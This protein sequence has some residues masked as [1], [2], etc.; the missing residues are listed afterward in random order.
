MLDVW[1]K[2]P[3]R[4]IC[5]GPGGQTARFVAGLAVSATVRRARAQSGTTAVVSPRQATPARDREVCL[6]AR[7][8]ETGRLPR[9]ALAS[10]GNLLEQDM[11]QLYDIMQ[12][13]EYTRL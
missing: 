3:N 12:S 4:Q 13:M 5:G 7:P 9:S 1:L 2:G 10:Q 11:T 8:A 6:V